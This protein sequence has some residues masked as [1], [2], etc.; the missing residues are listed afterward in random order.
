MTSGL[1][2]YSAP[3]INCGPPE[4]I[5]PDNYFVFLAPGYTVEQ[6]KQAVHQR[7]NLDSAITG[8]LDLRI[9][10]Y[11]YY[12]AVLSDAALADVRADPN[13]DFIECEHVVHLFD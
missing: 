2:P 4:D 13:V 11:I 12:G 7:A 8:V 3:I 9:T 5:V 6:H 1:I 10:D